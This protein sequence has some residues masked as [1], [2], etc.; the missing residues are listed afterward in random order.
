MKTYVKNHLL[1]FPWMTSQARHRP[2]GRVFVIVLAC[3]MLFCVTAN[4]KQAKQASKSE[5]PAKKKVV[6]EKA[7]QVKLVIEPKAMEVLKAAC[8][9]LTAAKSMSFTAVVTY[10]Y[11][12]QLGP[13]VAYTTKSDVALQRPDKLKVITPGD[14][15]ASEFYYNG[16]TMVAYAPTENLV[17][18]AEAPPTI[19]AALKV[20]Y[21]SAAIYF[22]FTDLIVTDPYKAIQ[23]GLVL[24]FY[25]GQSKVLGGVT[26]DMVAYA[27]KDV[28]LQAWIGI[29]DKL[30]R[31]IRGVYRADPS[32]LRHQLEL[33]NWML[34]VD[35]PPDAF[36]FTGAAN[37]KPMA[38]AHPSPTTQSVAKPPV[39]VKPP[40]KAKPSKGN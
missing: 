4:A 22:P 11:P 27:N 8:D 34:D 25:I 15:P 16:K 23:E 1:H 10:E 21:D 3:V 14:G 32:R 5:V 39:K 13:P 7:P 12:S 19:D 24:A 37:A 38:F 31:M 26:T 17:A 40:A 20:A 35:V 33:S 36:S 9:R 18:I 6:K 30:P 28:Y 2:I 29:D